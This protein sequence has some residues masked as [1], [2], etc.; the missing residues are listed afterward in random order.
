MNVDVG[1]LQLFVNGGLTGDGQDSAAE[2]VKG[3]RREPTAENETERA[4]DWLRGQNVTGCDWMKRQ[5][6][7][8][9]L[10]K[11]GDLHRWWP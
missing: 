8:R 3:R 10:W 11:V 2:V 4:N 9:R 6:S 7:R 1:R 5:M